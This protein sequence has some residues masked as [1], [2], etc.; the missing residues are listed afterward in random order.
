MKTG[1][2]FI[3]RMQ[4]DAEFRRKVN[5]CSERRGTPGVFKKRRLC[6]FPVYPD[7][8]QFIVR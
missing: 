1:F 5:A 4:E 8:E 6:F 2:E 3:Q 7:L